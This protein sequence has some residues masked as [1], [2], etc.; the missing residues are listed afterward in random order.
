MTQKLHP[1]NKIKC[2]L[3]QP[4]FSAFSFW[5]YRDSCDTIGAKTPSPPLGLIT[6]AAILPQHWE[7]QLV[8]LNCGP[9]DEARWAWADLILVGGMLPQQKGILQVIARAKKDGK[10][11]AVG[12]ADPSSQPDIYKHA[13]VL[14]VGEGE[15]AIPIWLE[16]WRA[17]NPCGLF[18]EKEKPDVSTSPVPRY[19]L[20]NFE[21]YVQIGVQYSR[22]CPFNCEFC[23]IIELFGRKP[24]TKTPEQMLAELDKIKSLGYTGSIDLVD[25]NFIG[26]KRNVKRNLLPALIEWNKKNKHPFYYCTEASMN[27]ADDH[28]LLAQ[29]QQADFRVIFMGIETPDPELLLKT[30][31]SQNTVKP[32]VDRVN[33]LYQYGM[34][35]TAGF[36]M[37]FDGEKQ[38]M[39]LAMIKLIEDCEINMAM[40]GLLVALPNTQLT[41]RLL[42]ERRLLSFTGKL[43]TSEQELRD[44]ATA[45]SSMLEVVDQTLAGLNFIT[46]RDRIDIFTEYRNVVT[47]VY[48][49]RRYFDRALRLGRKLNCKSRHRPGPF[50]LRRHLRGFFR[51]SWRMTKDKDTRWLYWRNVLKLLPRGHVVFEQVMRLMGIYLHFKRQTAYLDGV[52]EKQ[53]RKQLELPPEFRKVG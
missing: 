2:L 37:G 22:G 23:D 53:M 9:F 31:K 38:H 1:D 25:D 15:S 48:E 30:Q 51:L 43:V 27:L 18:K 50:E 10:M 17:G 20:L 11:V 34:V 13:D 3:V 40:V 26:N 6:V 21:H 29:M 42:K 12:G 32:I 14:V 44:S 4:E 47:T 49:P 33:T 19:D 7:Y 28:D 35:A 45:D 41:R 16:S 24:R 5:N 8:D 46:T 36:I 52:L 39:D